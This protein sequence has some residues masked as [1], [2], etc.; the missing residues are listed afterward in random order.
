M[1]SSQKARVKER[2]LQQYREQMK[3]QRQKQI[4]KAKKAAQKAVSAPIKQEAKLCSKK[5]KQNQKIIFSNV[6]RRSIHSCI[7]NSRIPTMRKPAIALGI[8]WIQYW[9]NPKQ[10][11]SVDFFLLLIV[12]AVT[13]WKSGKLTSSERKNST[14]NEAPKNQKS[15]FATMQNWID[16]FKARKTIVVQI[17]LDQK[18]EAIIKKKWEVR[19]KKED[20]LKALQ[21]KEE[22]EQDPIKK[23]KLR[24][25]RILG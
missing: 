23:E 20:V 10:Q 21:D 17:K 8:I 16:S 25:K 24:K 3:A 6:R 14:R 7:N 9:I 4:D 12:L 19:K 13:I 22:E 15:R 18:M 1:S 5:Q 2:N 11:G